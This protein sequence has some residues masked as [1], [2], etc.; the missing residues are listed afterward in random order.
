MQT[1]YDPTQFGLPSDTGGKDFGVLST[2][3]WR[4]GDLGAKHALLLGGLGWGSMPEAAVEEDLAA[5]R[6][7]V[8]RIEGWEPVVYPVFAVH[9]AGAP[10]G[11]AGRWLIERLAADPL[12]APRAPVT[13]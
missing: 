11:P 8:L 12:W 3:T 5:G 13:P 4:L 10:P 1:S 7:V 9:R 6:L 2:E